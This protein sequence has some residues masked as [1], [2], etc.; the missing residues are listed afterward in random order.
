MENRWYR[1]ERK[2]TQWKNRSCVRSGK[3][4]WIVFVRQQKMEIFDSLHGEN[5][6]CMI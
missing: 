4:I 6:V 3:G 2:G 5:S 1:D